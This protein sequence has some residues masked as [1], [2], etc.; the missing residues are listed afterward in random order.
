MGHQ[1]MH[2]QHA[3]AECERCPYQRAPVLW[4]VQQ[5]TLQHMR[6]W[7]SRAPADIRIQLEVPSRRKRFRSAKGR[8]RTHHCHVPAVESEQTWRCSL[9]VGCSRFTRAATSSSAT[10][11][12]M[13]IQGAPSRHMRYTRWVARLMCFRLHSTKSYIKTLFILSSWAR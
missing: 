11:P 8:H 7:A 9:A 2:V 3:C 12:L 10:G 1:I 5:H 6:L 4:P 13:S